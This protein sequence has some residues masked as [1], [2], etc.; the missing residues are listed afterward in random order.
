MKKVVFLLFCFLSFAVYLQ[1]QPT[2]KLNNTTVIKMVKAN[3]SPSLIIDEINNSEVNFDLS[4]ESLNML[5]KENISPQIIQAMKEANKKAGIVVP[6]VPA[7]Q[8]SVQPENN[9]GGDQITEPAKDVKTITKTDSISQ[10]LSIQPSDSLKLPVNAYKEQSVKVASP[11]PPSLSATADTLKRTPNVPPNTDAK[12]S[13]VDTKN[14]VK[15]IPTTEQKPQN[16]TIELNAVGY[17]IPLEEL[18]LF[19]DSELNNLAGAIRY[20][21]HGLKNSM[22]SGKVINSYLK[23][24]EIK[25]AGE[26]NA[27]SKG[28]T[29]GILSL[30]SELSK[31]RMN[32]RQFK[33]KMLTSG[34]NINK[35]LKKIGNDIERSIGDKFNTVAKNV[36][37]TDPDQSMGENCKPKAI[38]INKMIIDTTLIEFI[39]PATSLLFFYENEIITIKEIITRWNEE[40]IS[41]NKKN[42]ELNSQLE[43]INNELIKYQVDS[44]KNKKEI[45]ALKKQSAN[46]EKQRKQLT[47]QIEKASKELSSQLNIHCKEILV[48]L[49]QRLSDVIEDVGYAFQNSFSV[50]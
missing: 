14:D 46:I 8:V 37:A 5:A 39:S 10:K 21:D 15:T 13:S 12:L 49:N 19:F 40:V 32:Y 35:E 22:D 6:T 7:V 45:S 48:S 18:A 3:L 34:M 26:K 28:Y 41:V 9:K 2:E 20:W 31:S 24:I 44:R 1:A 27:N 29:N 33:T 36:R 17:V 11:Q 25:L 47:Q 42:I 43:P 16:E 38:T 23:E 50:L 30:R 4:E